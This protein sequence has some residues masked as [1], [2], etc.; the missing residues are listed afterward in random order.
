[1]N[2]HF[3]IPL[4]A[5]LSLNAANLIRNASFELGCGDWNLVRFSSQ[6]AIFR[7]AVS[8]TENPVHGMRSLR[9]ENPDA[10][11]IELSG[12]EIPLKKDHTYTL[13][14]Y[15]KSGKPGETVVRL[16]LVCQHDSG[17]ETLSMHFHRTGQLC[18]HPEIH[19]GKLGGNRQHS[20]TLD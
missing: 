14:W 18:I 5:A 6:D 3:L 17:M 12:W 13:S 4:F 7:K 10:D 19:L 2:R 20:D 15:A 1:M 16:Y 8:D 11:T 9:I